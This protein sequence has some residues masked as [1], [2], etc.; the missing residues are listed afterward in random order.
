MEMTKNT[1]TTPLLSNLTSAMTQARGGR[2]KKHNWRYPRGG[3][4][5]PGRDYRSEKQKK[6]V[7]IT[8][9]KVVLPD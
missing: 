6:N 3:G 5:V 2:E 7:P 8:L 9:P 1:P 4:Y